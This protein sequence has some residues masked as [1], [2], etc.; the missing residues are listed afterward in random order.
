M[1]TKLM[2][3]VLLGLSLAAC[4]K[5]SQD[6]Q[7][8]G[9]SGQRASVGIQADT[10][11]LKAIVKFSSLVGN[12]EVHDETLDFSEPKYEDQVRFVHSVISVSP[13]CALEVELVS[14]LESGVRKLTVFT[15]LF[16]KIMT[17]SKQTIPVDQQKEICGPQASESLFTSHLTFEPGKAPLISTTLLDPKEI[18]D[19]PFQGTLEIAIEE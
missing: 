12:F 17:D 4:S 8:K 13:N 3:L 2:S 1:N 16:P 9:E 10:S 7:L 14:K 15:W 6:A 5:N 19:V 18:E 11:P